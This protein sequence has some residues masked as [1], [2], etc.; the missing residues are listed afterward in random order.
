MPAALL[1]H[2]AQGA[3]DDEDEVAIQNC[4]FLVNGKK[5]K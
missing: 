5:K 4:Y 2:V 1:A 3:F